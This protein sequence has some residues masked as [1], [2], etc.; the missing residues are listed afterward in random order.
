M[1]RDVA[2]VVTLTVTVTDTSAKY[3]QTGKGNDFGPYS[4]PDAALKRLLSRFSRAPQ[5]LPKA[6][7]SFTK[8][9]FLFYFFLIFPQFCGAPTIAQCN[10]G[11][12]LALYI[13][14]IIFVLRGL[15]ISST[16]K[17][18]YYQIHF[19]APSGILMVTILDVNDIPP[20]FEAPWSAEKPYYIVQIQEELPVGTILRT[21]T[22]LDRDS[23]IHHYAIE[24]SSEYFAVN[25]TTGAYSVL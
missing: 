10:L 16:K 1:D 7:Q 4:V 25:E 17:D 18:F 2:A 21:F 5:I 3:N 9:S 6:L 20:S 12:N 23:D 15:P 11:G 14:I 19:H 24:P 22:A 13:Y 8:Y